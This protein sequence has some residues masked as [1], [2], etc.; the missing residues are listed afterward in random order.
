MSTVLFGFTAFSR[1]AV[2]N[3]EQQCY[4]LSGLQRHVEA[5]LEGFTKARRQRERAGDPIDHLAAATEREWR[6][7]AKRLRRE[8]LRLAHIRWGRTACSSAT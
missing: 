5:T 6:G 4:V 7:I 8:S 3:L 1:T 2:L